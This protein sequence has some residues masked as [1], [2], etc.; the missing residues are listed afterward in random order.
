MLFCQFDTYLDGQLLSVKVFPGTAAPT[1]LKFGTNV[2]YELLYSRKEKRGCGFR[3]F[4]VM[5]FVIFEIKICILLNNFDTLCQ[6]LIILIWHLYHHAKQVCMK[7]GDV[8]PEVLVFF[9]TSLL[10]YMRLHNNLPSNISQE[11]LHMQS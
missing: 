11:L 5:P 4:R 2:G 1:S 9:C 8:G 3:S 10:I 6:I 7:I